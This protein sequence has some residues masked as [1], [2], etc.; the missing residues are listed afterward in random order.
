MKLP[1]ASFGPVKKMILVICPNRYNLHKGVY[2]KYAIL[3]DDQTPPHAMFVD[4]PNEA[5]MTAFFGH[6]VD[7]T[8]EVIK[9]S[10]N[11]CQAKGDNP[12]AVE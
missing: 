8:N 7:A 11:W 4:N 12:Y 3:L 9:S 5:E 2:I 6:L 10:C 1:V